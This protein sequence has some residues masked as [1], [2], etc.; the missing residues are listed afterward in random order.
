MVASITVTDIQ[1]IISLDD[2]ILHPP[3]HTEWVNGQLIEK[4]GMT[5]KHSV[6]QA[7]L[8]S[9]WRS[10]MIS[11][12]QGGEVCVEALCRTKKQARRLDVAYITAELLARFSPFTVLPQSFPLIAEIASFDDSAEELFAKSKKYLESGCQEVW[13]LFPESRLV[14]VNSQDKWQLF[15]ANEIVC[16]QTILNGFS[17]AVEELL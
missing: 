10:H 4:T 11:S 5:F 6:A 2:F 3:E 15:N 9:G 7:K 13:L 8:T 16:I 17:I 14:L 1:P 12:K